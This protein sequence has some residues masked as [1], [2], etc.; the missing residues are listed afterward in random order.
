MENPNFG[1]KISAVK[2]LKYLI[3]INHINI[4]V[5]SQLITHFYSILCSNSQ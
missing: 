4:I 5:N 1:L 3:V 2:R